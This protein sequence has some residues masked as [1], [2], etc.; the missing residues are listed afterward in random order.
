MPG[1]RFM[2]RIGPRRGQAHRLNAQDERASTR[3][4]L[5][6]ASLPR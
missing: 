3:A 2:G 1:S 6:G 4:T 5:S